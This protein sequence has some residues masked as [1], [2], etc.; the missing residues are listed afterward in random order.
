MHSYRGR[1]QYSKW[2]KLNDTRSAEDRASIRALIP[3][4]RRKP[5]FSFIFLAV[6]NGKCNI[7]PAV[8]SLIRQLYP[9]WEAWLPFLGD[10]HPNGDERLRQSVLH[11]DLS[12]GFNAALADATGDFVVPLPT[13]VVLPDH[14]LFELAVAINEAPDAAILYTDEDRLDATGS[15]CSPRLKTGWDPDLTL[16]RDALGLLVAFDRRELR[17]TGGMPSVPPLAALGNY[18][19]SLH[20]SAAISSTRVRHVPAILC[21]RTLDPDVAPVWNAEQA[22]EVLRAHLA[23]I[24]DDSSVMPCPLAPQWSRLVRPLPLQ[25]PLVS[26]LV[27]TRDRADLL[28]RCVTSLLTGTNYSNLELL[29]ID[30]G[31]SEPESVNLLQRLSGDP[32]VQILHRP[33]PFNFSALNND[34]ARHA[35]GEI[36]VLLNSDTEALHPD[37]LREMVSHALRPDVGAVGARLLYPDRRVQHAGVVLDGQ[38]GV[39]VVHQLRLSAASDPGPD[40]ELALV[41]NVSAVTGA[42]LA[43]RRSVFLEIGGLDEENLPVGYNDID[44]CMRVGDHGYRVL[45]TPFAELLHLESATRG[46]D[47]EDAEKRLRDQ[48]ETAWFRATWGSMLTEDPFHNPN[49]LYGWEGTGLAFPPRRMPVWKR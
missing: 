9:H 1:D 23:C 14:A 12:I 4:L 33:G 35:R 37:W 16:C 8:D 43:I 13:D 10:V 31:S 32:R 15:R 40:G 47:G 25:L 45:V 17:R 24:G 41:R 38:R 18:A 7:D 26:V 34:A 6:T 5:T 11:D 29:I 39:P 2:V 49:L 42:C 36:L 48:R 22:R 46:D 21:H 3:K 27:P 20:V 28:V 44:L 30:N 19:L